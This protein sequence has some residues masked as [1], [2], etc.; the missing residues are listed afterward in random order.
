[1]PAGQRHGR[2]AKISFARRACDIGELVF[3]SSKI[4]QPQ[5]IRAIGGFGESRTA[6]SGQ[7]KCDA[8]R[9]RLR[10]HHCA[11]VAVKSSK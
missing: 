5:E 7:A 10:T 6:Q 2:V 9:E 11:G 1:M 3:R 8:E 4:R